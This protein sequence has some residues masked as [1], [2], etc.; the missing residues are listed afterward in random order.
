MD[1]RLRRFDKDRHDE[2]GYSRYD[3]QA[4]QEFG[5]DGHVMSFSF[6]LDG[7]DEHQLIMLYDEHRLST[8][9]HEFNSLGYYFE[10]E[11]M[12]EILSALAMKLE[13]F[14]YFDKAMNAYSYLISLNRQLGIPFADA[15]ANAG[16]LATHV[17]FMDRIEDFQRAFDSFDLAVTPYSI[18]SFPKNYAMLNTWSGILHAWETINLLEDDTRGRAR[19]AKACLHCLDQAEA[20]GD[21][22]MPLDE[23][24]FIDDAL[25]R[26]TETLEDVGRIKAER[27]NPGDVGPDQPQ[28]KFKK[29]KDLVD[30]E[31]RK[32]GKSAR[33]DKWLQ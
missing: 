19:H 2:R 29:A 4:F 17:P 30:F 32:W 3:A 23:W 13:N 21:Y 1:N 12:A 15:H 7:M 10:R 8:A 31:N 9:H 18:Q 11:R 26:A 22:P 5:I 33:L 6:S 24:Q 28:K 14:I 27:Q 25:A 16:I 20:V